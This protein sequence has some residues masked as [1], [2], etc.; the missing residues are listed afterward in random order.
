MITKEQRR[1]MRYGK[2]VMFQNH[3]YK[4][5]ADMTEEK[6]TVKAVPVDEYRRYELLTAWSRNSVGLTE[7]QQEE[8]AAIP[9]NI[10]CE[11]CEPAN[12]IRF[13]TSGYQTLFEV[14]DLGRIFVNGKEKMVVYID[15][16]HFYLVN[17][18]GWAE[19]YHICEF[20]ELCEH[21]GIAVHP[22]AVNQKGV[23]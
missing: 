10:P 9:Q 12:R 16:Y 19:C 6:E 8:L 2:R 7:E 5:V 4:L 13:I 1:F 20:A 21:N 23:A 17:G 14:S 3:E 15:D 18:T 22:V 11:E